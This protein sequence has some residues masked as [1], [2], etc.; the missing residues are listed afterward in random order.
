MA[1]YRGPDRPPFQ[2]PRKGSA[3]MKPSRAPQ[4]FG[5]AGRLPARI[6]HVSEMSRR[7]NRIAALSETLLKLYSRLLQQ[8][9]FRILRMSE[10]FFPHYMKTMSYGWSVLTYSC[11]R[12]WGEL[13]SSCDSAH[14]TLCVHELLITCWPYCRCTAPR[15]GSTGHAR[16]PLIPFWMKWRACGEPLFK[17]FVQRAAQCL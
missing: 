2:A 9:S 14:K 10:F 4:S 7:F 1:E 12:F 16:R 11:R 5:N 13:A 15:R 6:T 8:R 17:L 3:Q